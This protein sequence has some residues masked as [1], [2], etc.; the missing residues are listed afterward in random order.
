MSPSL[1]FLV[2]KRKIIS[3]RY[4]KKLWWR[5]LLFGRAVGK[6]KMNQ[7]YY[8]FSKLN[9]GNS[10]KVVPIPKKIRARFQENWRS[11][12]LFKYSFLQNTRKYRHFTAFFSANSVDFLIYLSP[13]SLLSVF[14]SY[15]KVQIL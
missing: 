14:H 13:L 9:P 8:K 1:E 12:Q 10:L 3:Q 7:C 15:K 2:Q 11:R 4:R 5:H 6:I